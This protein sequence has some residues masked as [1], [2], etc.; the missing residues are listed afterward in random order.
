MVNLTIDNRTISVPEGTTILDA[1][2]ELGIR[3]PTLCFLKDINEIGACRVCCVELEG[4]DQ[5]VA[6]CNTKVEEGMVIHTNSAKANYARRMNLQ[7]IL[8]DHDF[9]CAACQRNGACELQR[10]CEEMNINAMP[11]KH[12]YEKKVWDNNFPLIRNSGKCIKCMRCVQVCDKIQNVKVW[13]IINTGKRTSIGVSGMKKITETDC[14]LCGQCITHC[15]TGALRERDDVRKVM[16]QINDPKKIVVVQIAPAVRA[17]WGE[18]L[19]LPKEFATEK[20]MAAAAR[21]LGADFVFDTNFSADLTIMEEG[22]ELLDRLA[23]KED[24]NWPMFTSCCPGWIR[25][26]KTK[27]P[28][29]VGNLST[30]KS[31]MQMFGAVTKSYFSEKILD[32]D[33]ED[34]V[35]V[36]IMPCVAKKEECNIPNIN[37]AGAGKDVDFV[38]TTREFDRLLRSQL[39]RP[40]ELEE[41]E[42]DSPLG[43]GSGAAVIFGATG[44]V[45]EAALRTAY[46]VV[47]GQN[48]DPDAFKVVRGIEGVKE[49]TVTLGGA[50]VKAAVVN[51]LGNA[52]KLLDKIRAGEASYDFVEV[53]ACPG[54]CVGGGG[55]PIIANT[56]RAEERG[57]ELYEIDKNNPIRF[58]HENPSVI[59]LYKSYLSQPLSHKS[60]KLLHTDHFGWDV[61]KK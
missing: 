7:F 21:A 42:F 60:H 35:T 38:L 16:D 50:E 49:A 28:D 32:M 55:Q 13:D 17:A 53:M 8:S 56:E 9:R 10:I 26:C 5:L 58:S 14:A 19:G 20:R 23:H 11:F 33:P 15:P 6:S 30:A 43:T 39:I 36:A 22:N 3:I 31:P 48:P 44:G 61:V 52:S 25:F 57:K 1:A 12:G 27:Y 29:M 40:D 46:Y 37:D 59:E 34:I 45:M 4:K 47:E 41:E 24:H 18:G 2:S 54:G 51:G